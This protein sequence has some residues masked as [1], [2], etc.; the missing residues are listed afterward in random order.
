[1]YYVHDYVCELKARLNLVFNKAFESN[2]S[3]TK[4]RNEANA[5]RKLLFTK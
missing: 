4:R 3:C 5:K 1:M 2:I